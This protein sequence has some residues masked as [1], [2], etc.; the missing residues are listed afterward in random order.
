MRSTHLTQ[1][2]PCP[3]DTVFSPDWGLSCVL[4]A[5]AHVLYGSETFRVRTLTLNTLMAARYR[6]QSEQQY[7]AGDRRGG[8]KLDELWRS[9]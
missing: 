2:K 1:I 3:T 4:S 9:K 6:I 5:Y 7:P 8:T